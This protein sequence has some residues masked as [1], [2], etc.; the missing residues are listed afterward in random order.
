M[1]A[2]ACVCACVYVKICLHMERRGN[3]LDI[4]LS[5]LEVIEVSCVSVCVFVISTH[6]HTH[7]H[8][9]KDEPLLSICTQILVIGLHTLTVATHTSTH[10]HKI[11]AS[12]V[13]IWIRG[14]DI[15]FCCPEV[16][17]VSSV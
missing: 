11:S 1:C 4:C 3:L 8:T 13:C 12:Y 6:T 15:C 2:W 10:K 7:T 17:E 16:I 5:C 9:H 14:V